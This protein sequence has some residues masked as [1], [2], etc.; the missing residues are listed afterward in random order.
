MSFLGLVVWNLN[1]D[2]F[3]ILV[4]RKLVCILLIVPTAELIKAIRH[5]YSLEWRGIHGVAHWARV[6]ENGLRLA[7]LTGARLQVVR[8]FAVFHDSR[9]LNE[10]HDPDHGR[11]GADFAAK[12]RGALF[13]LPDEEF[14]LLRI[15]C[16]DHTGRG[17]VGDVTVQTCWDADRLDLGRVRI[18]PQPK[19]L[20]TNAARDP[21]ILSWAYQRSI[22]NVVPKN[23]INE[24]KA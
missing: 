9:R 16:A 12:L 19:Y 10:G 1:T 17:T 22:A 23:L 7:S 5:G 11:R 13:Q 24:W 8:L 4:I 3:L 20:C 2:G 21:D 14:E 6:L 15:A 18:R